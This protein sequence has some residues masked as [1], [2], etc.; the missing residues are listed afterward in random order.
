[1]KYLVRIRPSVAMVPGKQ[2]DG[3]RE[4]DFFLGNTRK[5][6]RFMLNE[7]LFSFLK[8]LDGRRSIVDLVAYIN[9]LESGQIILETQA[10]MLCSK[11]IDAC[12]LE[13]VAVAERI[14]KHQFRRV[15]SFLQD[16]FPGD[17]IFDAWEK[18]QSSKVVI[19]GVGGAGSWIAHLLI[20]SGIKNLLIL[21]PDNV[22]ES[23]LNRS[24]FSSA[25]IG[26][27]KVEALSRYLSKINPEANIISC[28][29]MI[30]NQTQMD[31]LVNNKSLN[32][33][34]DLI[35]NCADYPSVDETSL[36]VSR[37]CLQKKIPHIIAGGYNLHVSLIGPTI[38]PHETAC[39]FCIQ[40]GLEDLQKS[41]FGSLR[42]LTRK[43]RKIG[44]CGPMVGIA[45]TYTVHEA[46]RTIL[47][48]DHIQ[49]L[50]T[51]RRSEINFLTGK[52]H[53][54]SLPRRSDC[55]YCSSGKK[56]SL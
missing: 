1:M 25:D 55:L 13:P 31:D 30:N 48:G 11:L 23:N 37:A 10:N 27:P 38:L 44:S 8:K 42:K 7:S 18:L 39:F 21:D 19:L 24:L 43:D 22:E 16:Y 41:E 17:S 45:A 29:D 36:L 56:I 53:E 54:V 3:N 33:K 51:N 12:I 14:E 28:K 34:Q 26:K 52:T 4:V 50:M 6:L 5:S 40:K 32:G 46:I 15:F 2:K 20:R 47:R 9:E 35:I 49:P